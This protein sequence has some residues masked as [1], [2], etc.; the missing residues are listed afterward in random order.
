MAAASFM[1][2]TNIYIGSEFRS[3]V[4]RVKRVV[5]SSVVISELV[6]GY[7]E[8][9]QREVERDFAKQVVEGKGIV[10]NAQDWIEVGKCFNRLQKIQK[11]INFSSRSVK[12][13]FLRDALIARTAVREKAILVTANTRDFVILK[14]YFKSLTFLSPSDFFEERAR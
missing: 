13:E 10:P 5:W 3:K 2:D 7:S 14:T 8:E 4:A 12:A 6:A 9:R 1:F 11:D